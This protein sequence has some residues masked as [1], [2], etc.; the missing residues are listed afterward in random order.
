MPRATTGSGESRVSELR[1]DARAPGPAAGRAF[2]W[3][4]AFTLGGIALAAWPVRMLEVVD[5]DRE[6]RVA[7]YPAGS[8]QLRYRHSVYRGRVWEHFTVVGTD[9]VLEAV[10][11]EQEAALEYYGLPQRAT[12][13]RGRYRL[14]LVGHRLS[15]LVV[16]A[17]ATGQRTLLVGRW[18]LPLY[19]AGREGHRVRLQ[20][21][22]TSAIRLAL[23]TLLWRARSGGRE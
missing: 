20:V 13:H 16:R 19:A 21:V 5:L 15:Q 1:P 8:F 14:S 11:A 22:R 3:V 9:F 2:L 4:L 10:E 12:V 6:Q 17:T 23:E 7:V 18:S